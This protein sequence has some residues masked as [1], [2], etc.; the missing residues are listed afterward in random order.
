MLIRANLLAALATILSSQS[1]FS[2]PPSH[3]PATLVLVM[4][5]GVRWQEVFHGAD[6]RLLTSL[7]PKDPRVSLYGQASSEDRRMALMP[8]LWSVVASKG[9]LYGNQDKGSLCHVQNDFNYSYPGYAETLCGFADPSVSSNDDKPN[10]NRSVLEWVQKRPGF[11]DQ[12]AA[13]ATWHAFHWILNEGASGLLVNAGR[14]PLEVPNPSPR[15]QVLNHLKAEAYPRTTLD[16]ADAI[17]FWQAETYLTIRKPRVL[18]IQLDETDVAGHNGDYGAYLD[19][20]HRADQWLQEIWTALQ[21]MPEF[22][23]AANLLVCPDHGRG[24]RPETWRKHGPDHP[25]SHFTWLAAIGPG[26]APLGE[27]TATPTIT[28]AQIAATAAA[29]VGEDFTQ[30]DSR[31]APPIQGLRQHTPWGMTSH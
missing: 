2:Q 5:D 6:R 10:P 3:P 1:A 28:N 9:Q 11:Q 8:F 15:T 20:L 16:P 30:S 14:E 19:A 24:A 25:A 7:D 4:L 26:I 12:V 21:S 23:G 27:R 18:F 17:T 22:R 29:L 31:V 13:F